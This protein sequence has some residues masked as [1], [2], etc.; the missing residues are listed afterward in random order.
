MFPAPARTRPQQL[1]EMLT[2]ERPWAL[3]TQGRRPQRDVALAVP[4]KDSDLSSRGREERAVSAHLG[5]QAGESFP[6][7]Q[8]LQ[9]KD[10]CQVFPP[11]AH[12]LSRRG[13][14]ATHPSYP[15][16][17]LLVHQSSQL[18]RLQLTELGL[19]AVSSAPLPPSPPLRGPRY[20]VCD[21]T[22]LSFL[23]K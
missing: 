11:C 12:D 20:S 10:L 22:R 7:W 16:F 4:P 23:M 18:T 13:Q 19:S 21:Q 5:A 15:M 17:L 6:Q 1:V 8:V 2:E 3:G 9:R 14:R